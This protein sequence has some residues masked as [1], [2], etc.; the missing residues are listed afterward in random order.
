MWQKSKTRQTLQQ[1][2]G[3]QI[4]SGDGDERKKKTEGIKYYTE[5]KMRNSKGDVK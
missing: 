2:D 5:Q 1:K 4:R 3:K